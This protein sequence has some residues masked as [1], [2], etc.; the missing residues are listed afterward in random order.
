MVSLADL[1]EHFPL[2]GK[3]DDNDELTFSFNFTDLTNI[4]SYFNPV[5]GDVSDS[6]L[7]GGMVNLTQP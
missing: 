3:T 2:A 1:Q 7:N 6:E 5:K 4:F